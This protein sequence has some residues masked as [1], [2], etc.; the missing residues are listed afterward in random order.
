MRAKMILFKMVTFGGVLEK[1]DLVLLSVLPLFCITG[2]MED[3]GGPLFTSH[4]VQRCSTHALLSPLSSFFHVAL[5]VNLP[6][7]LFL[8]W[9]RGGLG[10]ANPLPLKLFFG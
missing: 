5:P 1:Q 3:C 2:S 8:G 9:E 7:I 6:L 10:G 4:S